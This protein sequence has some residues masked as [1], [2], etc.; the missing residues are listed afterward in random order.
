MALSI[1]NDVLSPFEY[2]FNRQFSSDI[3][4]VIDLFDGPE[5]NQ[6]FDDAQQVYLGSLAKSATGATSG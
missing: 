4:V 6:I 2:F 1:I 3:T 5:T